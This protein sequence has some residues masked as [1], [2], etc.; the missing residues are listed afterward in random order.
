MA[1]IFDLRKGAFDSSEAA[2][3][4]RSFDIALQGMRATHEVDKAVVNRLARS[5]MKV[6]RGEPDSL[7][8]DGTIDPARL[9]QRAIL[10]M[11]QVSA[12][13][14][15]ETRAPDTMRGESIRVAAD[16]TGRVAIPPASPG[17]IMMK[18]FER[19]PFAKL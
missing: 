12:P 9:A 15:I 3:L 13:E 17:K 4:H 10:R 5:I 18:L 16:G 2:L 11:L 7:R 6:A 14:I 8:H 1:G 19:T